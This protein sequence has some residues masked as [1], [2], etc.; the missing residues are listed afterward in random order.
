[1]DQIAAFGFNKLRLHQ[2]EAA[3]E[4]SCMPDFSKA[5]LKMIVLPTVAHAWDC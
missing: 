1:L 4:F 3:P 2:K 5:I